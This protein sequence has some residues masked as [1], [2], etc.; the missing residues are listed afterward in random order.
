MIYSI[1]YSNTSN[2]LDSTNDLMDAREDKTKPVLPNETL[3]S[4]NMDVELNSAGQLTFKMP[5]NHPY[6]EDI[7][8]MVTD[9]IVSEIDNVVWGGRITGI[10]AD[11]DNQ[12]TCYCEG[13]YA[14]FNDSV[15]P[16]LRYFNLTTRDYL[17]MLLD[18]HN[19]QVE[20]RHRIYLGDVNIDASADSVHTGVLNYEKTIDLIQQ[21]Q[22]NYGGY[23]F[24]LMGATTGRWE[25]YYLA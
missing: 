24:I 22:S 20:E 25:L 19:S 18:N 2:A 17:Q 3:V 11:F 4:A 23:I 14:Y 13:P 8:P 1:R 9:V 21:L 16:F 5:P 6:A 10:D 15:Q 7:L 12:L